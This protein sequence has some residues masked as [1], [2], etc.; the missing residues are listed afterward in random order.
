[1][2]LYLSHV[3]Q[4]HSH[5][6]YFHYVCGYLGCPITSFSYPALRSHLLKHDDLRPNI[7]NIKMTCACGFQSYLKTKFISHF[8]K[9]DIMICPIQNCQKVYNLFS[10]F[11]SHISISHSCFLA[12]E[13]KPAALLQNSLNVNVDNPLTDESVVDEC[14]SSSEMPDTVHEFKRNVSLFIIKMQEKF[15]LSEAVVH[16]LID[17]MSILQEQNIVLFKHIVLNIL[18]K[19]KCDF[20]VHKAIL[21]ELSFNILGTTLS[22]LNS[23]HLK[24]KFMVK[25]LGLIEPVQ[26]KLGFINNKEATFQ[27]V[28]ILDNL[29][30]FIKNDDVFD[31]IMTQQDVNYTPFLKDIHHGTTFKSNAIFSNFPN[32][33]ILLYFD[34]LGVTNPLRGHQSKHK[35]AVFYYTLGNLPVHFRSSI[36]DIQLAL[37]CKASYLKEFGLSKVVAPLINDLKILE[38]EGIKIDGIPSKVKGSLAFIVSDNLGSHQI[39][40]YSTNFNSTS[41]TCRFCLASASEMQNVFTDTFVRRNKH[42][43]SHQINM[44]EMNPAYSPIYGLKFQSP[45]NDLSYFHTSFMLP[46][47]PMH[48]LLEGIVPMELMLIIN[49]LISSGYFTLKQL[50]SKIE[51]F[52]Y[53]VNDSANKPY[54]LP[55]NYTKGLKLNASRMWCFLRLLPLFVGDK[56]PEEEPVWCLLLMLKEIVDIILSPVITMTYISYL[57]DLINDHHNLLK[58]L[59]PDT[60][61]KPKHHYLVHYPK[62]IIEFGPLI[63]SWS[64]R[65]ESKHLYF[66]RLAQSIKNSI[67]LPFSL[68]KRHQQ[69]QCYY[70]CTSSRNIG[71]CN[72]ITNAKP[73]NRSAYSEEVSLVLNAYDDFYVTSKIEVSGITFKPGMCVLKNFENDEPVFSKIIVIITKNE[74]IKFVCRT[75]NSQT[76]FHIGGYELI[77]SDMISVLSFKSLIDKYPLS[78]YKFNGHSVIIPKYSINTMTDT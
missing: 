9:H 51:A 40:G 76:Y 42:S 1:M 70:N 36:D 65:Y 17:G 43:H 53:G 28:P 62:L 8:K 4:V 45:F 58:Y 18:K 32:I 48:D 3:K 60:P 54:A 35:L 21:N 15:L 75:F 11:R 22:M 37:I 19:H 52:N 50:N 59:F 30:A 5:E 12:K 71:K 10:S 31:F 61:V 27:Y 47:D 24:T 14:L 2:D 23:V 13:I 77:R 78:V 6:P 39:G 64:M 74:E 34:E 72:Q 73:V 56:V 26:Y 63:S 66:K 49:K 25:T 41:V 57:S 38:N 68:A 44:I 29:Q 20:A 46:P 69:L 55:L 16:E 67:N 33:Q 7:N